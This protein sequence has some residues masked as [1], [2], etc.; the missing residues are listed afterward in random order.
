MNLRAKEG[1]Q[2][3]KISRTGWRFGKIELC[4]RSEI[5]EKHIEQGFIQ[6]LL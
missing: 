5:Q 3:Y 2:P 6:T 4:E 1:L